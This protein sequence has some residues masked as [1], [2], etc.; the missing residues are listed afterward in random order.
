MVGAGSGVTPFVSILRAYADT[1]GQPGSPEKMTLLVAYRSK[2]DLI[3]WSD[4]E[5]LQKVPGIRVFT[6]LTREDARDEGF[7]HGR[8]MKR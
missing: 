8:P 6:T 2:E 4:L 5:A 7:L 1:L 3:C